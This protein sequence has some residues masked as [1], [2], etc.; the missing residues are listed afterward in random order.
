VLPDQVRS[1]KQV[2]LQRAALDECP[3]AWCDLC[4]ALPLYS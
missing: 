1:I 3:A 2:H 4:P